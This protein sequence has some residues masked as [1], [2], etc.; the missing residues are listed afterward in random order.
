MSLSFCLFFNLGSD[1]GNKMNGPSSWGRTKDGTALEIVTRSREANPETSVG[2]L[3]LRSV[4]SK[5]ET[6]S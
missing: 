2:R 3:V 5:P 1:A 4:D 6:K